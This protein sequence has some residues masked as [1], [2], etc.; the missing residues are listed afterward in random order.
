MY[1]NTSCTLYLHSNGYQKITIP[2]CFLTH[3][4]I[5]A[6][7]RTGLDYTESA[8]CMFKGST[9]LSFTEGKDFLVEGI[10]DFEFEDDNGGKKT[11]DSIK[12]LNG[13]GA[14][15]IMMADLKNYGSRSMRHWELSCK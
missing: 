11:S 12:T 15:T 8:F 10:C 14:V 5:A 6:T 9:S 1:T 2:H 4:S 7:S 13:L 3:R